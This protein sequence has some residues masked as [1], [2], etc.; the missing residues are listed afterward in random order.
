MP[1][2]C[3]KG[4]AAGDHIKGSKNDNPQTESVSAISEEKPACWYEMK[5][6]LLQ[7]QQ[8]HKLAKLKSLESTSVE[9]MQDYWAKLYGR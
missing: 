7:Q 3:S 9:P 5:A 1:A 4:S 6:K 8:E 2:A